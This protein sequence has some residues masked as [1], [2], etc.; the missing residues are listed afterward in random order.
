MKEKESE[1]KQNVLAEWVWLI[2]NSIER[3]STLGVNKVWLLSILA[4]FLLFLLCTKLWVHPVL[5]K[6]A[7][8]YPSWS[9]YRTCS[10]QCERLILIW[11]YHGRKGRLGSDKA[12]RT[13][14]S[15]EKTSGQVQYICHIAEASFFP[16][17]SSILSKT[18]FPWGA[19]QYKTESVL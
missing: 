10:C 7:H 4:F 19:G 8:N 16:G 14:V 6:V 17:V 3:C 2:S 13:T 18:R 1:N 9:L 11:L 12:W 5:W 15:S